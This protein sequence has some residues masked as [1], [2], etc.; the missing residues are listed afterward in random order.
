MSVG[1]LSVMLQYFPTKRAILV[2]KLGAGKKL[3]KS[4]SGYVMTKK[5]ENRKLYSKDYSLA[6]RSRTFF[7]GFPNV[8]FENAYSKYLKK[9]IGKQ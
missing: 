3:S 5:R 8:R 4:I 6:I 9:Y 7:C 1:I 2:Q